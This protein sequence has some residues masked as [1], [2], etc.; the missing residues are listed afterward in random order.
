MS[1]FEEPSLHVFCFKSGR[2]FE[3]IFKVGL[4]VFERYCINVDNIRGIMIN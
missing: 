3:K 2:L 4:D 1:S